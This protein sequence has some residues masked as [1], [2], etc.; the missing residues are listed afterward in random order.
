MILIYMHILYLNNFKLIFFI[1][2]HLCIFSLHVDHMS[3]WRLRRALDP[4]GLKF[5]MAV[6]HHVSIGSSVRATCV[7]HC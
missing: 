2:S 5:W 6:I 7:L 3:D 1:F 4:L